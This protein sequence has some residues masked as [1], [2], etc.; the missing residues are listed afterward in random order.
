MIQL[1]IDCIIGDLQVDGLLQCLQRT[2][3]FCELRLYE[4]NLHNQISHK[5]ILIKCSLYLSSELQT[6]NYWC[7]VCVF[8]S[9]VKELIY[10]HLIQVADVTHALQQP[11]G[12]KVHII[13]CFFFSWVNV[14]ELLVLLFTE[15]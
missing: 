11:A 7:I 15:F 10:E 8:S 5:T 1:I 4:F 14:S 13:Y 3:G 9:Y 12:K 2:P 6:S